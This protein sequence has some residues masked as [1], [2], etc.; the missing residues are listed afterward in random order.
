MHY[1]TS[2]NNRCVFIIHEVKR[3]GET[4]AML[5]KN[6]IGISTSFEIIRK[7]MGINLLAFR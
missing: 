4:T 3:N 6:S 5:G 7:H 1:C 2:R